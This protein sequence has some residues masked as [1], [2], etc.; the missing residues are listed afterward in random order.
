[1]F[2]TFLML[3][4]SVFSLFG[5]QKSPVDLGVGVTDEG[6]EHVHEDELHGGDEGDEEEEGEGRRQGKHVI[7]RP[8]QVPHQHHEKARHRGRQRPELE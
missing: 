4:N 5:S 1:M 3:R 8:L 2:F 7:Q 6:D